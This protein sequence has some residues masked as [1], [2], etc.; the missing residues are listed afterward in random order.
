LLLAKL[1]RRDPPSWEALS[2]ATSIMPCGAIVQGRNRF[3]LGE[4]GWLTLLMGVVAWAGLL[5]FHFWL[6]GIAPAAM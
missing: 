2:A 6:F 1:A 5:H 3:V 4:I